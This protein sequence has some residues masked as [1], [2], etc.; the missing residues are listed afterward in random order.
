MITRD[1]ILKLL[2]PQASPAISIFMQ[3]HEAGPDIRKDPIRLK[4]LVHEVESQVRDKEGIKDILEPAYTLLEGGEAP[5]RHMRRGLAMFASPG[6]QV[7]WKLPVRVEERAVVDDRFY[8]RPLL[9]LLDHGQRFF[10]LTADEE[11]PQLYEADREG[12]SLLE[13]EEV[14]Q[15]FD[16]IVGKT[17]LP[18]DVGFHATG[19]TPTTGGEATAKYHA[20]GETPEDYRQ[21]ELDRYATHIAKA[22]DKHLAGQQAPLVLVAEPN[23]LGKLREHID[24]VGLME[25][26]VPHSPNKAG[27]LDEQDV[28]DRAFAIAKP[29]LERPKQDALDRFGRVDPAKASADPEEM[30]IAATDGRVETLMITEDGDIWGAWDGENRNVQVHAERRQDSDDLIDRMAAETLKNGGDIFVLDR[31]AMPQGVTAAAVFR[32]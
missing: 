29:A 21:V 11:A 10:I 4:N 26:S 14:T 24:Y 6:G 12:M 1:D 15:A 22:V 9:T 13:D 2:E 27:G 5:W 18:A 31:T 16:T 32:Y 3:T 28:Y 20:Q 23:L 17:E 30:M 25:E 7:T 8:I 19:P